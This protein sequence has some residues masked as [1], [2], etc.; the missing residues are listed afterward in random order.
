MKR[1]E[2][3]AGRRAVQGGEF[4]GQ[5]VLV[6]ALE[7]HRFPLRYKKLANPETPLPRGF[8]TLFKDFCIALTSRNI[9][10]TAKMFKVSPEGLEEASQFF[11]RQVLLAPRADHYRVLGLSRNASQ[12]DVKQHYSLIVR[13][14]HPD[15]SNNGDERNAAFTARINAA[16][17]ALRTIDGRRRYNKQL[18]AKSADDGRNALSMRA[19]VKPDAPIPA[20]SEPF[21]AKFVVSPR[22]RKIAAWALI[23]LFAA[24]LSFFVFHSTQKPLLRINPVLAR[25]TSPGPAYLRNG[26]PEPFRFGVSAAPLSD[27]SLVGI[28]QGDRVSEDPGS[29][30]MRGR[31]WF[32][33]LRTR[34]GTELTGV[35]DR[36]SRYYREGDLEGFVGLF[37]PDVETNGGSGRENIRAE[38]SRLFSEIDRRRLSFFDMRWRSRGHSEGREAVCGQ[39]SFHVRSM[40]NGNSDWHD[41]FGT[42][43]F[44]LVPWHGSYRIMQMTFNV[45]HR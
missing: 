17:N 9:E 30:S 37:T 36:V 8:D 43:H 28:K 2:G 34:A 25:K 3:K 18:E 15:R 10:A 33:E 20:D 1:F 24:I 31:Y 45:D 40:F 19:F 12:E 32:G 35:L 38:Y 29:E 16:Y 22:A 11:L 23:P 27:F 13:L 14:F 5:K 4:R 7:Y 26:L 44:E 39:G 42:V 21:K 41:G 6:L